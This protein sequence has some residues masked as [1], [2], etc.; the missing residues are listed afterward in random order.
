[1]TKDGRDNRD[2]DL[3]DALAASTD[4][5]S[6]GAIYERHVGRIYAYAIQRL[7]DPALAE[8]ATATTFSRALAAIDTF[9]P[10][11]SGRTERTPTVG[12]WLLTIARNVVIDIA[13][14]R[15]DALALDVDDYAHQLASRDPGPARAAELN[16]DRRRL[17]EAI[18]SLG[19]T[20]Q[21]IVL[22][23]FQGWQGPEIA[24]LLEMSP[25]AVRV[26]QH[27]AFVRL[28]ELLEPAMSRSTSGEHQHA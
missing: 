27:R 9:A 17:I 26:A 13:N 21:R 1:M 4:P 23:R 12:G 20:Q 15:R 10:R 7:H 14:S 8:D 11:A 3:A 22:L 25:G 2:P 6:F 16:D 18:R 5:D 24:E 19:T 28:R